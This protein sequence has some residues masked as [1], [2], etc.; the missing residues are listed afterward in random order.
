MHLWVCTASATETVIQNSGLIGMSCKSKARVVKRGRVHKATGT[1][2]VAT[3]TVNGESFGC[4][5][6]TFSVLNIKHQGIRWKCWLP[7][8]QAL[9]APEEQ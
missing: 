7:G 9:A 1:L 8:P 6:S 3:A 2:K 4:D 5:G